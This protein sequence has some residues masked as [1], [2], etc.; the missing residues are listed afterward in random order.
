[1]ARSIFQ[2]EPVTT[3]GLKLNAWNICAAFVL[4]M[5]KNP[6]K[7]TPNSDQ[8]SEKTAQSYQ[9]ILKH[10]LVSLI[11]AH[12]KSFKEKSTS[13][14]R[15]IKEVLTIMLYKQPVFIKV[16]VE[17]VVD[18]CK[19]CDDKVQ[20]AC[21]EIVKLSLVQGMKIIDTVRSKMLVRRRELVIFE[22]FG[23]IVP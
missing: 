2:E 20:E 23:V 13:N 11:I 19:S 1:M 16:F 4:Q 3:A 9:D 6:E 18:C 22:L 14:L 7:L 10:A 17:A 12:N 8:N 5:Y 21:F 15:F